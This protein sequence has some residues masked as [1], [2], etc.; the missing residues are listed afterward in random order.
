M[1]L[2][3]VLYWLCGTFDE[4]PVNQVQHLYQ[5][6][7]YVILYYETGFY[8]FEIEHGLRMIVETETNFG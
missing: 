1:E 3:R 8:L 6:R 2:P 4:L 5:E 7:F